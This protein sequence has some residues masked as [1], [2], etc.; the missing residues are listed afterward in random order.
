[1]IYRIRNRV[2]TAAVSVENG[3]LRAKSPAILLDSPTGRFDPDGDISLDG[4]R[5][6]FAR[7]GGDE[8][9][10][11]REPTVIVNWFEE[12]KAKVPTD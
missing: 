12:L 5:L 8:E 10:N 3:A 11:R 1:M 4:S 6:L 7:A 2:Y 9:E